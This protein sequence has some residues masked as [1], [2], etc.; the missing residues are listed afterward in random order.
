MLLPSAYGQALSTLKLLS[1]QKH[2]GRKPFIFPVTHRDDC[3]LADDTA[4]YKKAV[5]YFNSADEFVMS[6]T[7]G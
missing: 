6:E 7:S 5:C 4:V 1:L 3:L 2:E